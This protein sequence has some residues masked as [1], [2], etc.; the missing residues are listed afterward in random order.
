MNALVKIQFC[1]AIGFLQ[2]PLKTYFLIDKIKL[3]K[4]TFQVTKKVHKN[5][6]HVLIM[7]KIE[8]ENIS[9]DKIANKNLRHVLAFG[10]CQDKKI[11][12]ILKH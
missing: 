5:M 6:R 3:N 1:L 12:K 7:H 2:W 10:D 4:K 8:Q 9:S 11:H